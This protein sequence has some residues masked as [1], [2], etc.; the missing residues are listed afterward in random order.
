LTRRSCACMV[1]Y[2]QNSAV[3]TKSKESWDLQMYLTLV[4]FVIY[5]GQIPTKMYKDGEKTIEVWV[6]LLA[7]K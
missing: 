6:L 3:L 7:K 2:P 5:F 4:Y 1:D